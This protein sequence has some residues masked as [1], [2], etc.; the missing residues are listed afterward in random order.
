M[1][2]EKHL[3]SRIN[4]KDLNICKTAFSPLELHLVARRE[5]EINEEVRTRVHLSLSYSFE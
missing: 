3:T 1:E 4:L 2:E 5:Y